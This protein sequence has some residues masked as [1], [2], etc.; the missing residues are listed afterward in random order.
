[1]E[2][3]LRLYQDV[4]LFRG[5]DDQDIWADRS[6]LNIPWQYY[7]LALQLADVGAKR[8]MEGARVAELQE[9]A[10]RFLVTARG[11]SAGTPGQP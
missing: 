10:R 4:Y 6:S 9:D 1:M 5:I 7:A 11:G 8:G 3:S 2:R